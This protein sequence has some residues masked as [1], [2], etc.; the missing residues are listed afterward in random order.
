MF[1]IDKALSGVATDREAALLNEVLE[2][3]SNFPEK[4][5]RLSYIHSA[6]GWMM[7]V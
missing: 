5:S 2:P 3:E 7:I 1:D 4:P 6:L